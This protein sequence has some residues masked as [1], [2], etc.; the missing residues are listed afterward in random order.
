MTT[1]IIG[2][3]DENVNV[4][5]NLTLQ[6]GNGKDTISA[7]SK[8]DDHE[9]QRSRHDHDRFRPVP[10][11]V[12]VAVLATEAGDPVTETRLRI[13]ATVDGPDSGAD[14]IN[15]I[16]LSGVPAGVILS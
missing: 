9:R 3:G 2:D 4:G 12:S 16:Q 1:I 7:G 10:P 11:T 5:S 8:R 6:V 13:T 14:Y 15:R